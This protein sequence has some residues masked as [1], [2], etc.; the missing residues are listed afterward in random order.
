MAKPPQARS[1]SATVAEQAAECFRLRR[2]GLSIDRIAERTGLS[3]G[4]VHNRIT[5]AVTDLVQP[6]AEEY[7]AMQEGRLDDGLTQVYRVFTDSGAGHDDRMRAVAM[8][9]KVEERR[10][11]L[12]GLDATEAMQIAQAK[13][14]EQYIALMGE[15]VNWIASVATDGRGR[16]YVD[17]LRKYGWD[18]IAYLFGGREGALPELPKPLPDEPSWPSKSEGTEYVIVKGVRYVREGTHE[19]ADLP[20]VEGE[21]IDDE[22]AEP[23]DGDLTDDQDGADTGAPDDDPVA[24][25][26]ELEAAKA[27]FPD[28]PWS[29]DE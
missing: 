29:G 28:L 8:M 23:T 11:K 15:A 2:A 20:F 26:R 5:K 4:T 7:R 1:N 3:H 22:G 6:E 17:E 12:L 27:E 21:V 18:V 25:R 14:D 16:Y 19:P 9:V 24:V 10:A 13:A